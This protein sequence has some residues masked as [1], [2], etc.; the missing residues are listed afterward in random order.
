MDIFLGRQPIL[1]TRRETVAYELLYRSSDRS[2]MF[3]EIDGDLATTSLLYNLFYE[4]GVMEV[5]G[6]KKA[7]VNFT[8][9]LLLARIPDML[10]PKE[11]VVEV[12]EDVDLDDDLLDVLARLVK[13]GFTLALDDFLYREGIEPLVSL[14]SIVKVDWRANSP[15]EIRELGRIL[16]AHEI[17]LLAEKV[18]SMEEFELAKRLGYDLFQGFFFARPAILKGKGLPTNVYNWLEILSA[19]QQPELDFDQVEGIIKKNPS[20]S[21]QLLKVINSARYGLVRT[22]SSIRQAVVLLGEREIRKWLSLLVVA[23]MGTGGPDETLMSACIRARFGELVARELEGDETAEIV[24]FMGLLSLLDAMVGM[25]MEELLSPLPLDD[26]IVQA[27][28]R[29]E[30]PL[31]PYLDI[32]KAYERADEEALQ[33]MSGSFGM[34]MDR[35]S[36]LYIE[37]LQWCCSLCNDMKAQG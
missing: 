19:L 27:L 6:G 22:I 7:F 17:K 1:D 33:R 4:I 21:Y 5:T 36:A 34:G 35:L 25:S 8:R 26:R 16:K 14:A 15:D 9:D 10:S 23:R 3:P 2:N 28:L 24:F 37:A 30:G 18:E 32:V 29:N 31:A 11:V 20:L 12:L 13:R